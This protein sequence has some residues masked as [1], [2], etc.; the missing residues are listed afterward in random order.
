MAVK[1]RDLDLQDTSVAEQ[2]TT[3]WLPQLI[4][5]ANQ[6]QQRLEDKEW[7]TKLQN[8]KILA[9]KQDNLDNW[10]G[11]YVS[12]IADA[13][14]EKAEAFLNLMGKYTG[15]GNLA[16]PKNYY[17]M[18]N[19]LDSGET[20]YNS[21]SNA[22]RTFKTGTY[23]QKKEAWGILN[24]PNANLHKK[25]QKDFDTFLGSQDF[26]KP[27]FIQFGNDLKSI[28]KQSF[29]QTFSPLTDMTQFRAS[30]DGKDYALMT[31]QI[32]QSLSETPS[33][34]YWYYDD[35]GNKVGLTITNATDQSVIDKAIESSVLPGFIL[36][37]YQQFTGTPDNPMY[38]LSEIYES[39][40]LGRENV[41]RVALVVARAQA[42]AGFGGEKFVDKDSQE[43][44]DAVNKNLS[45]LLSGPKGTYN[46]EVGKR[47]ES[48]QK[49]RL[50][51]L[52]AELE[53]YASGD[54][55]ITVRGKD[56][57][58]GFFRPKDDE[59]TN[60]KILSLQTEINQLEKTLEEEVTDFGPKATPTPT[61][62]QTPTQTP[63]PTKKDWTT[64]ELGRA[65]TIV[66]AYDT[67]ATRGQFT[68]EEVAEARELIAKNQAWLNEEWAKNKEKKTQAKEKR[69]WTSSIGPSKAIKTYNESIG[70]KTEIHWEENL[71]K[72][73]EDHNEKWGTDY[74]TNPNDWVEA[75]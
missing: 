31:T 16:W 19:E 66:Q 73:I 42:T 72:K 68:E 32:Q 37:A 53:S 11:G 40:E 62:T 59:A 5:Q 70:K 51:T 47:V 26:E 43:Y 25:V 67:P 17:D 2:F 33:Q 60:K 64:Q 57:E 56:K 71:I 55:Y 49:L 44:K 52:R 14:Y 35:S 7:K 38:N 54:K 63:T 50:G 24:N 27:E 20:T 22:L 69:A 12:S 23:E 41:E 74:S 75:R 30:N 29:I 18:R 3:Q 10:Y 45:N 28:G 1:Y 48:R 4:E 61:P 8:D 46:T 9:D 21:H 6:K 58:A 15:E 39:S 13:D 34:Q 36:N 65:R